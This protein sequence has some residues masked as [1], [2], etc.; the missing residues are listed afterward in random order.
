MFIGHYGPSFLAKRA[1]H[2]IPLWILFLAVQLLDVVWGIFVL[3]GIERVRIVPGFTTT[4]ALDLYYMPY[5]H[6]LPGALGWAVL[7]G[8]CYG[9]VSRSVRG[10]MLVGAAVFSHW[11]LDLIV[12]VPDLALYDDTAKVGLGLWNYPMATLIVEGAVV[13]GC[14]AAYL[15]TTRPLG[16][17]GVY[18]MPV[19][20]GIVLVMQVGMAFGPP[21]PSGPAMAVTALASYALLAAVIAWLERYRSAR[22]TT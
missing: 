9:L 18:G 15:A 12:H 3:I 14:L 13:L 2:A 8:A 20:I 16:R 21:P 11:P 17:V 7:G 22:G 10:A 5:T 19:F 6:S 1:D 4:N